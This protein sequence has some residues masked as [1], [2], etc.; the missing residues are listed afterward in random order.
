MKNLKITRL[1]L[2]PT[3]WTGL[4]QIFSTGSPTGTIKCNRQTLNALG[5]PLLKC[6]V[7]PRSP[8]M[9][10]LQ[11]M[12]YACMQSPSNPQCAGQLMRWKQTVW[13]RAKSAQMIKQ[14]AKSAWQKK[15]PMCSG[16]RGRWWAK[17]LIHFQKCWSKRK[18]AY[19]KMFWCVFWIISG[20]PPIRNPSG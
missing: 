10:S 13:S 9:E 18:N 2:K 8:C 14:C 19:F 7:W 15:A 12:N 20:S 11:S 6:G 3:V 17:H 5:W 4:R 1:W 16:R